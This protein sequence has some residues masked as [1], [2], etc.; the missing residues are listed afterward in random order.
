MSKGIIK[1]DDRIRLPPCLFRSSSSWSSSS[2]PPPFSILCSRSIDQATQRCGS[3]WRWPISPKEHQMIYYIQSTHATHSAA[4]KDC[5]DFWRWCFRFWVLLPTKSTTATWTARVTAVITD[6]W[7]P[8]AIVLPQISV[9]GS[10]KPSKPLL[11]FQPECY[12]FVWLSI[13]K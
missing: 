3:Y 6:R 1:K 5:P 11:C 7:R 12:E 10:Y 9:S 2:S 8:G 13:P 4:W